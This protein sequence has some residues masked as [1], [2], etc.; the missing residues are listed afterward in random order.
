MATSSRYPAARLLSP[1]NTSRELMPGDVALGLA[2]DQ[3]KTL[4]GS[5]VA[6]ILTDPRRTVGAMCHIVHVGRVSSSNQGNTAYG[7]EAMHEMFRLLTSV[8][9]IPGR[10]H[11]FVYGGGNMFPHL[12]NAN[13]VG[14]NNARWVMDY[15]KQQGIQVVE[16]SLGGS[17]YRKVCWEVGHGD[18]WVETVLVSE[19]MPD[20]R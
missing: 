20:G 15:L 4:L 6:V 3:L 14:A 10:C 5:C 17:G 1:T 18:P 8:G 19:E 11:A 9:V 16:E 7:D 2:G 12:F 13:H